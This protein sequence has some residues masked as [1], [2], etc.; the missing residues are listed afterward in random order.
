[1]DQ[2][3]NNF[4]KE[5]TIIGATGLLDE[6]QSDVAETLRDFQRAC[7]FYFI[8]RDSSMDADW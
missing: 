6:L 5:L 2:Y 1:M 3:A 8:F 7:S 4:E